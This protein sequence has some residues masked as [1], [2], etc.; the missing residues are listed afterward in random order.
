MEHHGAKIIAKRQV[1]EMKFRSVLQTDTVPDEAALK[2]EYAAAE[3]FTPARIG[4]RHFFF[5]SGFR[6]CY[7][8]LSAITRVF[9]RVEIVN[10]L[11]GC[12]NNGMPM[13]SIVLC[14]AEEKEIVQV[15]LQT[16]RMSKALLA[17]LEKACPN[18]A[19]GYVRDPDQKTA[20]RHV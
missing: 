20:I 15:R 16:E 4:A 7:V 10:A 12:C 11:V 1:F 3:D 19:S 6:T 2:A 13:E 17:A 8:P 9:R 14:G 5:K 18:A